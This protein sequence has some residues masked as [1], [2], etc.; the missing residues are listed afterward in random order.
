MD[1][2]QGYADLNSERSLLPEPIG[3]CNRVKQEVT[4]ST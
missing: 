1:L 3:D 2:R 4:L